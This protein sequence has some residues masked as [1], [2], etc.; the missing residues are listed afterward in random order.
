M[1]RFVTALLA[2]T[3]I[4]VSAATA[5][6]ITTRGEPDSGR[7]PEVG[8]LV[9]VFPEDGRLHA[10]CTGTLV[11]PRVFLTA[12]HC[13][14]FL[15]DVDIPAMVSFDEVITDSATVIEGDRRLNPL[16]EPRG[17]YRH[18][19][20]AIVLDRDPDITPAQIPARAG[21]LD[22]LKRAKEL[23]KFTLPGYGSNE[24]LVIP[25]TGP[26]FPLTDRRRVAVLGFDALTKGFIHQSQSIGQDQAGACYGDS[27]GPSFLGSGSGETDVV[28]AVT[29]TGDGPC[30]ATNVASRTD[31]VEALRFLRGL[32]GL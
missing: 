1:R 26:T 10:L 20:S 22:R 18:D 8:A 24:Q 5:Q 13:V 2:V 17:G 25:G 11:A 19:V 29:S 4:A 16:Y 9:A 14:Q 3:A 31:T 23:G 32:P 28:V 7:H 15:I 30:Y 21:K 12:S 27:G 6:A